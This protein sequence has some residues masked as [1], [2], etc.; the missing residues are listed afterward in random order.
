MK[1]DLKTM[2]NILNNILD[3][4]GGKRFY[5]FGDADGKYVNIKDLMIKQTCKTQK[6]RYKR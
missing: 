3:F 1:H 2:K 5:R 6:T 4:K